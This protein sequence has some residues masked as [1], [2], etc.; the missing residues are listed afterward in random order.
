M[1]MNTSTTTPLNG[2]TVPRKGGR[3]RSTQGWR[4][5]VQKLGRTETGEAPKERFT[6]VYVSGKEK[7]AFLAL[8]GGSELAATDALREAAK[9]LKASQVNF[10]AAVRERG[11][12]LLRSAYATGEAHASENN[13][14]WSSNGG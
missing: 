9:S 7:L 2:S 8:S 14:A 11:L 5:Y 4:V 1:T 12:K 10:S 3:P 13:S 6:C